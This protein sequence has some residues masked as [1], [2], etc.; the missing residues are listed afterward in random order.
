MESLPCG[1]SYDLS[2]LSMWQVFVI[3]RCLFDLFSFLLST[4]RRV[5]GLFESTA[6]IECSVLSD[7]NLLSLGQ[8]G[9]KTDVAVAHQSGLKGC[10]LFKMV[11]FQTLKFISDVFRHRKCLIVIDMYRL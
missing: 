6:I 3:K 11:Y 1:A 10:H 9:H 2:I 4:I 5:T 7:D 8:A